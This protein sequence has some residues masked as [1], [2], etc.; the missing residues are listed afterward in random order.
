[1]EEIILIENR[2]YILATSPRSDDRPYVLKHAE[3]F[4]VLN[5]FGDIRPAGPGDEG[6]YHEGT[7]FLNRLTL[8]INGCLP[9]LLSSSVQ[10]NGAPLAVDLTNPDISSD[11]SIL[12]RDNL[13]LLRTAVLW[14]GT[15]YMRIRLRNY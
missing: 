2:H 5:H 6:L 1:M 13:H 14:D 8:Q 3:T 12:P 7:R 9:L 4:A 11:W 10:E 15:L